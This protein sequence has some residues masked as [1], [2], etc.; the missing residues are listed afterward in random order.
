MYDNKN[1]ILILLLI[2]TLTF[3]LFTVFISSSGAVGVSARSAALYEPETERFLYLKD[4]DRRLAMAST[5]KIM[6]ALLALELLDPDEEIEIDERALGIEG[7]SIYLKQ[8]ER[9]TA[10]DLVYAVLLQSANDAAEA[11]AYEISGGIQ[12]FA[13]LMNERASILGLTDTHF[14]NPHGLDDP[15]H[16]TTAHDLAIIA[17]EAL[18]NEDFKKISST[19]KK[20]IGEGE[21]TRTVVNHNKM[22][23]LYDGCIGVK[24]GYTKKSG[25]CLVSAAERDGLTMI[26]VTIDAPSDWADH[27]ELLDYGY[28]LLEA[29][30]L[31]EIGDFSYTVPI[32]GG[33]RESV[34]VENTES[35]KRIFNK[36]DSETE[37]HI[38]LSR[39]FS[40]PISRGDILGVV[41][42]TKDG[43]EIASLDLVATEDVEAL[44][45]KKGFPS[46]FEKIFK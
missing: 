15:N 35:L 37:A 22:L 45:E 43:D 1:K 23:K 21:S 5:T 3:S 46:I 17:A 16:Y 32:V 44:K 2:L 11:I 20:E 36:G 42:F 29:K 8:G 27:T 28:S 7:S 40:A 13:A 14:T 26:S 34:K 30:T 10:L 24:T 38:R 25:R 31:A 9:M 4:S 12:E 41:I 19:Y 18:K 39:Y 6:T 33:T